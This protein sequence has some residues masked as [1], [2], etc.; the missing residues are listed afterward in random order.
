MLGAKS[1]HA[2]ANSD[3]A[4]SNHGANANHRA[5]GSSHSSHGFHQILDGRDALL[6]VGLFRT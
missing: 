1:V 5:G 6:H 3:T 4:Y 2:R